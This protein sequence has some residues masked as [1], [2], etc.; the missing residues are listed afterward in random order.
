MELVV[1]VSENGVIGKN[2]TLLWN[3]P[4]DLKHFYHLTKHQIVIMG[5]KTLESI[6]KPLKNRIHIVLTKS[7]PS[8]ELSNKYQSNPVDGNDIYFIQE[9]ET[10]LDDILKKYSDRK[11]FVIG[12]DSVYRQFLPKCNTLHVTKIMKHFDGDCFFSFDETKYVLTEHSEKMY[13][14]EEDCYFQ[15]LHFQRI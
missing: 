14:K 9:V 1:A 8:D 3:I 15:Y 10:E 6:G 4:E 12:G 7:K 11:V 5:R 13:S 2:N